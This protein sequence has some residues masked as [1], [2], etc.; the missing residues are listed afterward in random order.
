MKRT[1]DDTPQPTLPPEL[2][3]LIVQH[4][5]LDDTETLLVLASVAKQ[6][7][8]YIR[9]RL[10]AFRVRLSSF[11]PAE[12]LWYRGSARYNAERLS[13]YIM[14]CKRDGAPRYVLALLAYAVRTMTTTGV[15]P[16]ETTL[17]GLVYQIM[18]AAQTRGLLALI[19]LVMLESRLLDG[20]VVP[21]LTDA[22]LLSHEPTPD[23]TLHS[24]FHYDHPQGAVAPLCACDDV[25]VADD[26]TGLRA[27]R[28]DDQFGRV[29]VRQGDDFYRH[30]TEAGVFRVNC[31]HFTRGDPTRALSLERRRAANRRAIIP[32][33]QGITPKKPRPS[34]AQLE[35]ELAAA[36]EEIARLRALV[37]Q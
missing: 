23:C 33:L 21:L 31:F 29:F 34:Y 14:D 13:S 36:R 11:R 30:I 16:Y 2:H 18:T 9:T 20:D 6:L 22:T 8:A 12:E 24:V 5:S 4:V 10:A 32:L 25:C 7:P 19:R 26:E 3:A 17:E 15:W 37:P 27:P 28:A 1:I 35:A